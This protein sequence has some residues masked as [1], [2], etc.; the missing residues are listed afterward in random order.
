MKL[1]CQL[2]KLTQNNGN[3]FIFSNLYNIR[4]FTNSVKVCNVGV[5]LGKYYTLITI[6]AKKVTPIL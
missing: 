6:S 5:Q 4:Q 2:L 3:S 1:L